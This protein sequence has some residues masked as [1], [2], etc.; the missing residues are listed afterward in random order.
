M[1]NVVLREAIIEAAT[2]ANC[3]LIF[4]ASHGRSGIK[5]LLLGSETVESLD[6]IPRDPVLA[7]RCV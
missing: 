7:D 6:D 3:D 5:A 1:S 4:M 2:Q